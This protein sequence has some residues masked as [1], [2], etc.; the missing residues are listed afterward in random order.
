MQTQTVQPCVPGTAILPPTCPPATKCPFLEAATVFGFLPVF[1][2]R[3]GLCIYKPV[4][5]QPLFPCLLYQMTAQHSVPHFTSAMQRGHESSP[6]FGELPLLLLSCRAP[7]CSCAITC[8]MGAPSVD[9]RLSP[10]LCYHPEAAMPV[11]MQM[12][13]CK[14]AYVQNRLLEVGPAGKGDVFV[15]GLMSP[16]AWL[17]QQR[18]RRPVPHGPASHCFSSNAVCNPIFQLLQ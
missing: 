2:L 1:S 13:F 17:S 10:A 12:P 5:T 9:V 4:H 3:S 18:S 8:L 14:Y 16:M 15:T 6:V 7:W 11:L